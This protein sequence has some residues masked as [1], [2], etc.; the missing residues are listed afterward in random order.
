MKPGR[1]TMRANA[2]PSVILGGQRPAKVP[3]WHIL[4]RR[5][6]RLQLAGKVATVVGLAVTILLLPPPDLWGIEEQDSKVSPREAEVEILWGAKIPMRDGI[7]LNGT[8]YKPAQMGKPLP[9]IFVLTPYVADAWHERGTYFVR[10]GYVFVSVDCRGRGNSSG[11]FEPWVNEARD[12]Y[13]IVEWLARQ[14]WSDG[15]ITMW[16][17][18]YM[19]FT[20]WA[21]LSQFP[22]HLKTIVPTASGFPGLFRGP[23]TMRWFTFVSGVTRNQEIFADPS[24]WMQKY[25]EL[26]FKHLPFKDLDRLVGNPSATFQRWLQ[27]PTMD[28]YWEA[29]A[30]S[31]EQYK[32]MDLPILTITGYY[33]SAQSGAMR[34]Y[35]M[36]M[37]YASPEA[38][39]R[40]YL[41]LGPWDHHSTDEPQREFGGWKF[42]DASLIDI[43][44]LH[45]EWYNWVLKGAE[46]P[47][48]LKQRV[49]YYVMGAEQWKYADSLETISNTK[50]TLYLSSP[51]G[52][53]GDV[54]RSG[55]LS[56]QIPGRQDPDT[57][58]YDPLDT[59]PGRLE[60]ERGP[61]TQRIKGQINFEARNYLTDQS[62]A[63]NLGGSGLIYHSE[64]LAEDIEI[65][66]YLKFVAWIAMDVP[67]TDF[68]VTVYEIM[69]DGTGI[70]L[71]RDLGQARYRESD[72]KEKLIKPGEINR[73]EFNSFPFFSRRI[74]KGSRL[75]LVF[76]SPNS[77]Y[78]MK[79]YN[80]GGAVAEESGKQARTAHITLYHDGEHASL[81]ELAAVK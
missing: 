60:L 57:Y 56:E 63:M 26:Y 66:G 14:P 23:V 48:F 70:L 5:C 13:D 36:H 54:F 31:P 39:A 73:Y 37:Q 77:I 61:D 62:E 35:R 79:N 40:H 76:R 49:A 17:L 53:A 43:H 8:V 2:S 1:Q 45:V 32:R 52:G 15:K 75:R 47:S 22:P 71:A 65:T 81:L 30:P 6:L 27:H 55:S 11:Q 20:Q 46:K 51:Q 9:V 69:C 3:C 12:G 10:N 64:P 28:A 80:G 59:L 78:L 68:E 42:G 38:R 50:L 16:G 74:A 7:K 25:S 24:F 44:K 33:D 58:T 29:M 18:S 41:V 34:H 72:R 67:D 21:A 19:G 4:R